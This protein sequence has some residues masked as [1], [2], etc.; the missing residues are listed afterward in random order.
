[1]IC[2]WS[3]PSHNALPASLIISIPKMHIASTAVVKG[4]IDMMLECN[5]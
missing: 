2:A 1:M 4:T 3:V 5:V